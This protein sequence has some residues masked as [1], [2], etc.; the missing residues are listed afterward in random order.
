MLAAEGRAH[1]AA[2]LVDRHAA[3]DLDRA[4]GL[5][6]DALD[7]AVAGGYADTE[8]VAH[9]VLARLDR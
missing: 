5:A 4:R 1:W 6:T 7:V 2:M 3:G 8:A 9:Q